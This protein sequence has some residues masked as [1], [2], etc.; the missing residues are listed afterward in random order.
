[1]NAFPL[2]AAPT[3]QKLRGGYYTP[4]PIAQF[5][6]GWVS[7][8]GSKLLEP[9]CGDGAILRYLPTSDELV[10]IELMA[11]EAVKARSAVPKAQ[12][13]QA[14]FFDW[15]NSTRFASWDGVVGNPPFIR[16]Q[17]WT[18]PTRTMAFDVMREVS[19]K[20]TKLTNA[21]VPFV[22]AASRLVRPGGRLAMVVPAELLQVTYASELRAFLVDGF[23]ELTVVTFRR[24]VFDGV[25]Q[26][27]VLLLG[28][29]GKGPARIRRLDKTQFFRPPR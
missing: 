13:V 1:M 14:D 17:H 6:A 26:E 8:A 24:L 29:K 3:A 25:L 9:S 11:D 22:V 5:L 10:G 23:E 27:V 20:P 2:A 21:W 12:V 18:E 19:M 28:M 15:L 4:P 7:G 16:F